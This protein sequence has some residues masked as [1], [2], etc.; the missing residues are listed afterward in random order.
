MLDVKFLLPSFTDADAV[1]LAKEL[2]GLHATARP[3]PSERDRNFLLTAESGEQFVLK[4]SNAADSEPVL[5]MQNRALEHL[6]T[7]APGLALPRLRRTSNGEAMPRISASDGAAHFVRL[8]NYIPGNVLADCSPHTPEL[9]RSLG[10]ALGTIDR[11]LEHFEHPAAKRELKW[12][13]E[14]AGWIREYLRH[15]G[16]PDRRVM[17]ERILDRFEH[18]VAP[19]LGALRH[20]VIYNDANDYNVVVGPGDAWSRRVMGVIDFGDMLRT[21]TVTELAVGCAYAMLSKPDPVAAAAHIVGGYHDTFPLTEDELRILFP[22]IETRLAVSVT[23]SAYQRAAEPSNEYLTISEAPAW[24]L[25]EQLSS[26]HPRL[27]HYTFRHACGLPACPAS[28][29]IAAWLDEN[30]EALGKIVEPDPRV[31]R[32]LVFDLGVGSLE[33]GMFSASG[34]V[35]D[36][37]EALFARMKAAGAAVGIGRY[38]EARAVYRSPAFALPGNDGPEWRTIHIGLDLFLEPGAP[39][40]APLDGIVHSFR[41]N[42][43]PLDYGPTIVLQ[44][45]VADGALTFFTLYGHL[46]LDSLDG[47]A[48]G[49]RIRRGAQIASIGNFPVNGNWPPHLHFQII[50]DMLGREGDFPGVAPAGAREIWLSIS[51]DPNL[52]ARIPSLSAPTQEKGAMSPAEILGERAERI[53]PSLSISYRKPLEIVRGSMQTLYDE[54]GRPYLDCVNNVAHVGHSHPRVVRAGARQMAVLNTNTRYLHPNLVRYARRLAE[55][56]PAPLRVCYFVC[57]G[58][59]ANELALRLARARTGSKETIV[60]DVA[61]HGNTTSL[62][63]ISPYKF[64]GPGGSGAPPHVHK[65]PLPDDYRGPYRRDDPEAGAKY[66]AHVAQAIDEIHA[67]GKKPG[68]FIAESLPGCGGQIVLPPGF[69]RDAYRHVRAAGGVTIADEVQ[70]GFGRVGTH[71]WGFETQDVAPDIVTMGKP[72]GNGH[73]LGAVVTTAEIAAAFANGMEYFNT[74]GGNPVSCAI[75]LE[76][77]DVIADEHL[78]EHAREVGASLLAGLRGLAEKYDLI[79]DVRGLGLFVGVE[80]V[81]DRASL[82]AAAREAAYVVNRMREC[83][84][85]LSTDGPFHNVIKIKPPLPFSREDGELVVATLDRVFGDDTL[86]TFHSETAPLRPR[87]NER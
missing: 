22:L 2:Y 15:I 38:N 24:R 8:V 64:D 86:C 74:F 52:I 85:L 60:L 21:A 51:P 10:E 79:G 50:A 23:N 27:A 56:L 35:A 81:R 77:L 7:A 82:E 53:G 84:I 34:D 1:R 71:F 72:L 46:S 57:S 6:A 4:I 26:I 20:S 29:R 36:A 3:L 41:N 78:Q 12:D 44:H 40:F 9:L 32:S 87:I 13:L 25:L 17:V 83:G 66:A 63:E 30:P 67:Q 49:M 33:T 62:I 45:T 68:A 11:A 28:A 37:T 31:A 70:T 18:E 16:D 59:E 73:P 55:T 75:G 42:A 43:A 5:D 54:C 80:L 39:V 14:R 61:Y 65:I 69:L 47:L 19:A 76:V 48:E 58:S